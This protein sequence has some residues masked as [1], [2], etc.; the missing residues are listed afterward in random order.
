[1]AEHRDRSTGQERCGLLAELHIRAVP[2]EV[3]AGMP[4]DQTPVPDTAIDRVAIYARLAQL[5]TRDTTAL[6]SGNLRNQPVDG[7]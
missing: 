7:A 6:P 2:N 3:H 4:G 5:V 1:M